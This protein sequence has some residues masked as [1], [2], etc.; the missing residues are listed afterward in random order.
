LAQKAFDQLIENIK[1]E[2][3]VYFPDVVNAIFR[4]V[5]GK[6]EAENYGHEGFNKSF[7]LKDTS[8]KAKYYRTA[9]PVPV[10]LI[11]QQA[12]QWI[13]QQCIKLDADEWTAYEI[14][15]RKSQ[16][17]KPAVRA[18]AESVPA[19]F[20]FSSNGQNKGINMTETDWV[21]VKLEEMNLTK[22][23]NTLK[24]AVS[25]GTIYFDWFNFE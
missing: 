22:G 25:S 19:A 24:L 10:E 12:N 15:S 6:V 13:S 2:N 1:L 3:C 23:L 20:T 14:N 9:E 8:Q 17:C 7:Y 21:E 5:P 16:C 11:E 4:R 18:K